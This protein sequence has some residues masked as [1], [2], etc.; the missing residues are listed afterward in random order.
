MEKLN[1]NCLGMKWL[2]FQKKSLK[3]LLIVLVLG[4]L[5][6]SP[7][8]FSFQNVFADT[9]QT[10]ITVTIAG[11][12]CGNNIKEEGEQ[13]DG[14]DLAGKTCV[15][16]GYAGGTLKCKPNCTFDTSSCI[17]GGGGGGGGA[18]VPPAVTKVILEGKAYPDCSVT[19]LKDGKVVGTIPADS[20]ANFKTE[21]TDITPGIWS[22]SLWSEDKEGRKS[23]SFSFT[24]SVTRGMTTTVS[25]I[26]LPPT[27]EIE[28]TS[29]VK[30][31]ILNILGVTA[32]E[33]EVSIFVNSP[34]EAIIK[35]TKAES[36][37]TW[38]YPF[39][40]SI[41]DEGSH[42]TKA[43]ATEPGGLISTFSQ[44]LGFYI[45]KTLAPEEICPNADLNRDGRVNLV[46]FSILLYWWGK[47]NTCADQNQNGIVDLT[48]FSIMMYYWTG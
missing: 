25:G 18:S 14:S 32:P 3:F 8:F 4:G 10:S 41:L 16:L 26:F 20:Q 22:F 31:E 19:I 12:V 40:T 43:K 28:K 6:S 37:G 29:L 24:T 36:D 5:I 15:S 1:R 17:S 47:A 35:K 34:G 44:I 27:I 9:I 13:C 11:P 39:D 23:L 46:D 7:F 2:S 30:G 48:D 21:I 42:T 38:F 33:S 45:G